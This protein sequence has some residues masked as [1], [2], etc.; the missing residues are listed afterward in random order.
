[1]RKEKPREKEISFGLRFFSVAML[2]LGQHD[3]YLMFRVGRECNLP[4]PMRFLDGFRNY[5]GQNV[6]VSRVMV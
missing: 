3:D 2:N 1:V 5:V 4:F 6:E